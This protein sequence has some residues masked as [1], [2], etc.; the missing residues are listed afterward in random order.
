MIRPPNRVV[1]VAPPHDQLWF[2]ALHEY[3]FEL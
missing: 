1:A 2:F 3:E